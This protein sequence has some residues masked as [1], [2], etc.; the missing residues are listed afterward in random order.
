MSGNITIPKI[1]VRS[2]QAQVLICHGWSL[3][4]YLR[5]SPRKLCKESD[6]LFK[7]YNIRFKTTTAPKFA[8]NVWLHLDQRF[9][10]HGAV[11]K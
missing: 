1:F 3:T 7:Q 5:K 9:S 2:S 10:A 6:A 11:Q 4:R 8:S